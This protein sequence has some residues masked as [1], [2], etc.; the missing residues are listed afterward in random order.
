MN[1]EK[2]ER[3]TPVSVIIPTFHRSAY[4]LRVLR[5]L[6][7]QDYTPL[8]VIVVDQGEETPPELKRF[9]KE[10][11]KEIRY[12]R[13]PVRGSHRARNYGIEKAEGEICVFVDDD[14]KLRSNFVRRHRDHYHDPGLG[15]VGGSVLTAKNPRLRAIGKVGRFNYL[16]GNFTEHFNSRRAGQIDHLLGCN[17]SFRRDLIRRAG[18]YDEHFAGNAFFEELDLSLR[19]KKLGYKIIFEP[20]ALVYHFQA[21]RGGNRLEDQSRWNYWFFHNYSLLYLKNCPKIYLGLFLYFRALQILR[22][23]AVRRNPALLLPSLKGL[24]EGIRDYLKG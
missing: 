9:L 24:G 1:P 5:D 3:Q 21:G 15:G 6:L 2:Q 8:E 12:F 4:L 10:E 14:V 19:I 20:R 7:R 16:T 13:S 23:A 17:A 22:R 18:G 11:G